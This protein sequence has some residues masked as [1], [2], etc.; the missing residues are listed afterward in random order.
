MNEDK[1]IKTTVSYSS[2]HSAELND[3]PIP[4]IDSDE[5]FYRMFVKCRPYTMTGKESFHAL[6]KAVQYMMLRNLEGAFVECGVWKGGS[7]LLAALAF[8]MLR[9][10]TLA[11]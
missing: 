6:Y 7:S 8:R 11:L 9:A 2:K 4:D 5:V 3:Y 10:R 1:N